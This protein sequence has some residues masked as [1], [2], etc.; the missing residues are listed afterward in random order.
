[1]NL[2][3]N[4]SDSKPFSAGSSDDYKPES[5][6][7]SDL[8][9]KNYTTR[10]PNY[11]QKIVKNQSV[12]SCKRKKKRNPVMWKRNIRKRKLASGEEHIN[13][14]DKVLPARKPDRILGPYAFEVFKKA[15]CSLHGISR[16]RVELIPQHLSKPSTI[17]APQDMRG[18]YKNNRNTIPLEVTENI[19]KHI[20]EFPRRKLHYGRSKNLEAEN[21]A[22]DAQ[23]AL[24]KLIYDNVMTVASKYVSEDCMPY[25]PS[26]KNNSQNDKGET[27]TTDD[28]NGSKD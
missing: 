20:Q 14:A 15:F 12:V 3:T 28:N 1:M 22:Y 18:K 13:T 26:L 2:N 21:K 17:T 9:N 7:Y 8:E 11:K 6:D 5:S 4:E 19:N 24:Q 16:K 27:D 10:S 23:F 25:Y